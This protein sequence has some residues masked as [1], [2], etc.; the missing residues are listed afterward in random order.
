MLNLNWKPE[1]GLVYTWYAS[2]MNGQVAV[3]VNNNFGDIPKILLEMNGLEDKL[4]EISEFIL[5]ESA[6]Y[7]K[8]FFRKNGNTV[9]DLYSSMRYRNYSSIGEIDKQIQSRHQSG[10]V[11]ENTIPAYKG[12]YV[13]HAVEG[14]RP[15]EDYPVGFDGESSMGDYF[16]F[17]SP[18]IVADINDF[19][20]DL[21]KNI[22]RSEA[23]EFS[24]LKIIRTH[25]LNVFF[26]CI[27][28]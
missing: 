26:D 2:D 27:C 1:F 24:N 22:A 8:Y 12:I 14:D 25:D 18:T 19:P 4:D 7:E 23:I 28:D 6:K 9:L 16:R 21:R 15:G 5:E 11:T 17:L 10:F 20:F 13:Y 3:F